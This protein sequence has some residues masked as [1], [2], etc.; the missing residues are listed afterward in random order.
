MQSVFANRETLG[1]QLEKTKVDHIA[2]SL[3]ELPN[4]VEEM[5][6]TYM[7]ELQ[8]AAENKE[9][10]EQF[11]IMVVWEKMPVA[12]DRA[13]SFVFVLR[14]TLPAMEPETDVYY[15]DKPKG[16]LELL[17]SLPS[18]KMMPYIVKNP[19]NFDKQTVDSVLTYKRLEKEAK[20]KKPA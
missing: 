19:N 11:Y 20:K 18:L 13:I 1:T 17:W 8:A 12:K 16:R 15:V 4:L 7:R 2:S 5:G 9:A 6:K 3:I 10:P 14:R